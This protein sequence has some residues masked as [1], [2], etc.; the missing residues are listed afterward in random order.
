MTRAEAGEKGRLEPVL[1]PPIKRGN[2]VIFEAE[3]MPITSPVKSNLETSKPKSPTNEQNALQC[4]TP[5]AQPET[6]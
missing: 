3:L 5:N 6:E 1:V 4:N 2:H